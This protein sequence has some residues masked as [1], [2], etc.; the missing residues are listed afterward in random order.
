MPASQIK[1]M[2]ARARPKFLLRT[3]RIGTQTAR[4]AGTDSV[5]LGMDD[6]LEL[7]DTAAPVLSK[8]SPYKHYV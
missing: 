2:R 5:G 6:R 4:R 3:L 7:T 8:R 1:A